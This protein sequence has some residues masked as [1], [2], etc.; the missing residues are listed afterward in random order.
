M[1]SGVKRIESIKYLGVHFVRAKY[2]KCRP[3]FDNATASFYRAFNAV[4]LCG[5]IGRK[6]SEES[7][8]CHVYFTVYAIM[9]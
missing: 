3:N 2:F 9:H 6:G 1:H 5:R 4:G 8:V 7:N